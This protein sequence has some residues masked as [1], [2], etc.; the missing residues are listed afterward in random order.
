MVYKGKSNSIIMYP[1][2]ENSKKKTYTFPFSSMFFMITPFNAVFFRPGGCNLECAET[3][4]V[5]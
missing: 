5:P 2:D 3:E 1:N 4:M